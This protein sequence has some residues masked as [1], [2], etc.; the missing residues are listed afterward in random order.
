MTAPLWQPTKDAIKNS[1][2]MQF[3]HQINKTQ[4][5]DISNYPDLHQ[6]S[7]EHS[8]LFWKSIWDFNEIIA[9]QSATTILSNKD[10]MDK[11]TWFVDAKLNFA[12]NLLKRKDNHTAIISITENNQQTTLTYQELHH[13][14]AVWAQQLRSYGIQ[15]GDR[16][17]A[18]MPNIPETIIAMFA[19]ISIG[20]VWSSCSPDFG[21]QGLTDRFSQIKPSILFAVDGHQYN[22]KQHH[23]LEKI[24]QLQDQLP[25]L[26]K[27]II[28][29]FINENPDI[30]KIKNAI[31]WT[32]IHAEKTPEL[33]FEQLPFNHPIYILYSS[34]TT[35]KPKCMVHGAGGTLLQHL[36]EHRL[37]V[38][39]RPEDKHFF[40]T[41]C[42]WMMW[43]WLVSSL[44]TGATLIL[45]DGAPLFPKPNRLFDLID[46]LGITVFGVGAKLIESFEKNYITPIITHSLS[47][48]RTILTTGSP[49]L[50][51][52]FD[53]VYTKIKKDLCLSSISGGSD[54]VS[55]FALGNPILPVYS[56]ELQCLGLGMNVKVF[57]DHGKAVTEEKG[58]LVC[59]DPFPAMPIYFWNDT[60]G[61]KFH[62]AYFNRYKNVW[63]HG[64]YAK[65]TAHNG[66]FIYG[67][68]DATL[69]PGGIRIGTAE[70]YQQVEKCDDVLDCM[71][72]GQAW[73][74]SERIILFIVLRNGS[75][76]N[77]ALTQKIKTEIRQHASP[78]HVPAKIIQVP[79]LPR[80][81]SGKIVELAVKKIIHGKTVKNLDAL[82]NPEVL[83]HFKN[84]RALQEE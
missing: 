48:L 83:E 81:I 19:A 6:W 79:D 74:G 45:Y 12:E 10:N 16:I 36:K 40:Y 66:L 73:Q 32:E 22:G 34:G 14:V 3:I 72:V 82:A 1:Q 59:T 71:A 28:I 47:S 38:D 41:T 58:E 52:S 55:C 51:E 15:P 44:A 43:N 77:E 70:I 17:A 30:R 21:L 63:A 2:M 27:T 25:D 5:T 29:P 23:D 65:I 62:N 42:G 67:R 20:A 54:I 50:P 9:S 49:L 24:A 13:Q 80:T 78:H 33:T 60:D 64:D 61:E 11:A 7:I 8:E 4:H 31:L 56:G 57:N 18:F 37:H 26:K 39:L 76:L 46:K 68:S 75:I 84:L 53:Y 35:G 69:N